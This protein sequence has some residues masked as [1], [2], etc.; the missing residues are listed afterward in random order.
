M[1]LD[2]RINFRLSDKLYNAILKEIS[3]SDNPT[4]K[5]SDFVRQIVLESIRAKIQ[6][7]KKLS[8]NV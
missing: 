5:V 1:A 3:L 6:A 7:R 4:I 2:Q 8:D